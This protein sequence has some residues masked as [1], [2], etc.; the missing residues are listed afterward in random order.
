MKRLVALTLV[1]AMVLGFAATGY[2]AP[3]WKQGGGLPPGIQKK[4][5]LSML[6]NLLDLDQV[7][8]AKNSMEKMYVKGLIQGYGDNT[9]KP[10]KPVSQLEAV[11]MALRI[12]GWEED[13]RRVSNLPPKYSGKKLD[14]W[15]YGYVNIAY[16]KGI[17]DEVDLMYFNPNSAAERWEVAKYF[18]RALDK[19]DEAEKHMNKKLD[20]KDYAAIPVGAVG[21]IYVMNE[22]GL[23]QG[24]ADG[25]FNPNGPITRAE[26]AVLLE[27]I[28]DKVDSDP[29]GNEI[30][31]RVLE[32]DAKNYELKLDVDGDQ[33]WYEGIEGVA[34]YQNG[35][36]FDFDEL[37]RG[38]YVEI[39]LNSSGKVIF[40]ELKEQKKDED[41]LITNFRGEVTDVD[42]KN[43]EITIKSGTATFIFTVK[44][45][46][47]IRLNGKDA[48]LAD[49]RKGD[50]VRLRVDDR[51]RVIR[52]D[53]QGDH[54]PGDDEA[55]EVEGTI[56]SITNTRKVKE[57]TVKLETGRL[58]TY[59]V[60]SD[61]EITL[62]GKRAG[63]E[64]LESGME[65][66][67]LAESGIALEIDAKSAAYTRQ[68]QGTIYRIRNNN[69]IRVKVGNSYY[70]FVID[71]NTLVRIDGKRAK[72]EDLMADMPVVVE[73]RGDTAISI[74]AESLEAELEGVITG[75]SAKDDTITVKVG[76]SYKTLSVNRNTKV[77]VNGKDA[78][79]SELAVGMKVTVSYRAGLALRIQAS[80][81]E[82]EVEGVITYVNTLGEK[83]NVLVGS[84]T[85]TYSVDDADIYVEGESAGVEDLVVG[86]TA[87]LV[88]V[89]ESTV[90]E[91]NARLEK[92]EGIVVTSLDDDDDEITL[93]LYDASVK[94]DL[95]EDVR[96]EAGGKRVRLHTIERG[97]RVELEFEDGLVV[98]IKVK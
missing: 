72:A 53:A 9:F 80:D 30:Y 58:G 84:K 97:D 52:L 68:V 63:L 1:M 85:Y 39:L 11:I 17:L 12:M 34:V 25:T 44:K 50:T 6:V 79:F 27:R 4:V 91:V 31:G 62:D 29:E 26:M 55:F 66:I 51:N 22:L 64:D 69:Q 36:Y 3:N 2:A 70:D 88:L 7:P 61:T 38:D 86:M 98:L 48:D 23:M 65:V 46:A 95:D 14:P 59:S 94:Y 10:N 24:N 60:D 49:I 16:K 82:T 57:I 41:K 8:W 13:A 18:V 76:S 54:E 87:E 35:K 32:I 19:E 67:V 42:V 75:L 93:W 74:D 40:I 56:Y 92:V 83:I 78:G 90:S 33:E 15:A 71:G 28:D 47:D 20:F 89:N 81:D 37:K 77:K 73:Y 96:A 5:T 45:D 21:Y 43:S